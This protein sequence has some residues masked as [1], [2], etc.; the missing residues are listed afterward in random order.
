M[1]AV[2]LMNADKKPE[3]EPDGENSDGLSY[4]KPLNRQYPPPKA[5]QRNQGEYERNECRRPQEHPRKR[6]NAA[7]KMERI[8]F[9]AFHMH[10]ISIE[11]LLRLDKAALRPRPTRVI[12]ARLLFYPQEFLVHPKTFSPAPVGE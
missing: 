1:I 8:V 2:T 5:A 6:Q 11:H 9:R 3:L 4:I 10:M 12:D 7:G